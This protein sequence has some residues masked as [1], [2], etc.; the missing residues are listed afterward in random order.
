MRPVIVTFNDGT[1]EISYETETWDLEGDFSE[2]W[3]F[4]MLNLG[5]ANDGV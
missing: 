3:Y 1:F 5:W 4:H 2:T